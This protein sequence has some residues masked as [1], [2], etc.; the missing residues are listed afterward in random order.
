MI[1]ANVD[2]LIAE[3]VK[4]AVDSSEPSAEE[5]LKEITAL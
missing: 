1:S 2:S 3:A 4:F 5:F